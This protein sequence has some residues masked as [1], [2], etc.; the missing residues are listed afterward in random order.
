MSALT[1]SLARIALLLTC[2]IATQ[3]IAI[4]QAD[5]DAT[6]VVIISTPPDHPPGS[7]LYAE[8]ARGLEASLVEAAKVKV[9]RVENWPPAV[10]VLETADVLVFYSKPIGDMVL[11]PDHRHR[12]LETMRRGTGLVAIHWS[13]GVGYGPLGNDENVRNEFRSILGGWF[14]R[15]PGDVKIAESAVEVLV[16]DHPILR[17][18]TLSPARDEFYLRPVM[19]DSARVLLQVSLDGEMHPVG[20]AFER[21]DDA[22]G[23]SVG[24]T[25]GHFHERFEDADFRLLITNSILWA[26]K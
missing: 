22:H 6:H 23:R 8:E 15:P 20:W 11:H 7:H 5:D 21:H 17:G 19:H 14:R 9:T 4:V 12:F 25:L 3:S 26:A 10:E 13:T 24:I 18:V 16:P 1:R 2:W